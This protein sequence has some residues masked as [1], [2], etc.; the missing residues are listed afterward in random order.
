MNGFVGSF[1]PPSGGA[2]SV[3]TVSLADSSVTTAKLGGDITAAGKALLDDANAAAQRTTLGLGPTATLTASQILDLVSNTNGVLLTR[4]AG[5]WSVVPNVSV[6]DNNLALADTAAPTAPPAG[7]I[8]PLSLNVAGRSALATIDANGIKSPMQP[9]FAYKNVGA[10]VAQNNTIL[11][12][13]NIMPATATG[14]ITARAQSSGIF[15]SR[16]RRAAIVSAAGAGSL[17]LLRGASGG[18]ALYRVDGFTTVTRFLIS[19]AV[20]VATARMFV[21]ITNAIL[22]D[23]DPSTLTNLIGIGCDNGDT[24]L[25]LYAAGAAAQARVSLGANFPV[26]TINTDVYEL[27]LY[28]PPNGNVGY[29]VVRINTAHETSG[30]IS[31]AA[32]LPSTTTSLGPEIVRTNGGTAAAVAFDF[33]HVYVET[34]C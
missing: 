4:I 10:W 3:G 7:K 8:K 33:T 20:L 12:F 9:A 2:G 13:G 34:D 22:T 14:T 31:A 16:M 25:Q 27:T 1:V 24:T 30:T 11:N 19:D 18:P 29:R 21:G 26:N 32:N 28:C 6:H 17:A 23:V 5:A 15:V